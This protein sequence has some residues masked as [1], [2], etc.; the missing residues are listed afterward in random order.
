MI[1]LHELAFQILSNH[2]EEDFRNENMR[3]QI[4]K[5]I[6]EQWKNVVKEVA[7]KVIESEK[8]R[9]LKNRIILPP[10]VGQ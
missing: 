3:L 2:Q 5:E 6:E 9:H 10:S 4:A 8:L 7:V 1:K